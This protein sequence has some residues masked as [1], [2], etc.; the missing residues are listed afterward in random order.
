MNSNYSLLPLGEPPSTSSKKKHLTDS[1]IAL[2]REE[3]AR[4]RKNLSE[5]KLED[6]KVSGRILFSFEDVLPQL[7]FIFSRYLHILQSLCALQ[8]YF[9]DFLAHTSKLFLQVVALYTNSPP[10]PTGR[11]DKSSPQKTIQP[12]GKEQTPR[13]CHSHSLGLPHTYA[14]S[15]CYACAS[16]I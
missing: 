1:E 6:E 9:F 10:H 5:K 16:H 8:S 12:T 4:K 14:H 13:N 2:R 7:S 15:C 11:N 3:T